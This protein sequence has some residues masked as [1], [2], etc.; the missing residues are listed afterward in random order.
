MRA[1]YPW[2]TVAWILGAIWSLALVAA[3]WRGQAPDAWLMVAWLL[4]GIYLVAGDDARPTPIPQ[5]ALIL[6][7]ACGTASAVLQAWLTPLLLS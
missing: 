4:G 6:L 2:L 7:T 3:L 1:A 5:W